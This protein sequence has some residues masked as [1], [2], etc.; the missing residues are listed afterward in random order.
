MGI[1]CHPRG[2]A[3]VELTLKS[4]MNNGSISEYVSD[5]VD[6]ALGKHSGG[7]NAAC[8]SRRAVRPASVV[9][10]HPGV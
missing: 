9:T 7:L 10:R 6:C 5:K 4:Y 8:G 3:P 1:G 2:P